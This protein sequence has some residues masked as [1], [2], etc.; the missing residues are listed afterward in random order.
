[1]TSRSDPALIHFFVEGVPRPWQRPGGGRT[2]KRF[3]EPADRAW[4][5]AVGWEAKEVMRIKSWA[6]VFGPFFAAFEFWLPRPPTSTLQFPTGPRDPDLDNLKKSVLDALQGIVY[7]NDR[8]YVEDIG[9]RKRWVG[10]GFTYREGVRR[11]PGVFVRILPFV[12]GPLTST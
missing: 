11:S 1:M 8:D 5:E 12:G 4:R 9:S 3:T 2:R 6:P 7:R 10:V